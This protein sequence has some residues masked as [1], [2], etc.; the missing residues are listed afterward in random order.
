MCVIC[1]LCSV[2]VV[3]SMCNHVIST[4]VAPIVH[5]MP[6]SDSSVMRGQTLSDSLESVRKIWRKSHL[7]PWMRSMSWPALL[8]IDEVDGLN[9][10]HQLTIP[11]TCMTF[12]HFFVY[13]A[14]SKV[15]VGGFDHFWSQKCDYDTLFTNDAVG[16]GSQCD[17]TLLC[18]AD[19]MQATGE[20]RLDLPDS[21]VGMITLRVCS[22]MGWYFVLHTVCLYVLIYVLTFTRQA[23]VV[24]KRQN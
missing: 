1:S 8:T 24:S 19:W 11:P 17:Y 7:F 22:D 9:I 18:Y 23:Q 13:F 21:I 15:N 5:N 14:N 6:Y 20:T 3:Q 16:K 12:L 4:A 10:H 2:F